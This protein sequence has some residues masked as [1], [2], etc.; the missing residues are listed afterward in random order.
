MQQISFDINQLTLLDNSDEEQVRTRKI[1][2]ILKQ[3]AIRGEFFSEHEKE[4][5]CTGVRLSL[6]NDGKIE[7]Y[8][9]C[10]NP[11]FKFLYLVYFHDLTGGTA[12]FKPKQTQL[13][14]VDSS[15][16]QHDLEYLYCKADEWETIIQ[17]NNH[18]EQLLQQISTETR[19]ELKNLDNQPEIVNDQ[20]A[21]GSFRYLFKKR[22]IL[23]Q[24]KYI[25]CIAL[26][27]FEAL[28]HS[29][30]ILEINAQVIEFNEYSL[31]HILNRHYSEMTKQYSS[32][33]SF[34]NE[35]FIPRILSVQIRDIL[36]DIDNSK[37]LASKSINKIAFQFH[38]VDYLLW[39][40]EEIKSVKGKGNLKY[41]R[42]NTFYPVSDKNELEK[43]KTECILTNISNT[44]S[45][46]VPN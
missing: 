39:T 12:Y 43:L 28:N 16:A 41:R 3:R 2:E 26:E 32:N 30:L 36:R 18:S 33:K 45:V 22:A 40:S 7:D 23:L 13:Y 1:F 14:K 25:Y 42:L 20:F 5:F 37:V 44:I 35:D 21:K 31:I 4:F 9:C 24:S 11:K 8:S 29:D 10:D 38:N 19:T 34:H 6:L 27:I 46:Y 17:K 15:E